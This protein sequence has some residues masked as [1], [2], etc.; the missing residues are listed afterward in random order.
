MQ[1]RLKDYKRVFMLLLGGRTFVIRAIVHIALL[2][3]NN[4]CTKN[5]CTNKR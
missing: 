1:C 5:K 2:R 4:S 3:E